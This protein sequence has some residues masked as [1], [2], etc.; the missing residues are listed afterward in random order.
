MEDYEYMDQKHE[1][2][3]HSQEKVLYDEYIAEKYPKTIK[4]FPNRLLNTL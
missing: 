4:Y 1:I 3:A 2:E